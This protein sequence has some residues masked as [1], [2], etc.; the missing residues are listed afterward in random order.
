VR[1]GQA[2]VMVGV[3]ALLAGCGGGPLPGSFTSGEAPA[4]LEAPPPPTVP[5]PTID[6]EDLEDLDEEERAELLRELEMATLEEAGEPITGFERPRLELLLATYRSRLGPSVLITDLTI[7]D[8]HA[9]LTAQD[10]ELTDNL[11]EYAIRRGVLEPP[12]PVRAQGLQDFVDDL[13]PLEEVRAELLAAVIADAPT[14]LPFSADAITHLIIERNVFH[15][16]DVTIR[17]Y[18]SDDRRSGSVLY[19][20]HGALLRVFG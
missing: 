6:L 10:P 7:W 11:D 5:G 13:F 14:H 17:V 20:L 1:L 3:L 12:T 19:A 4:P 18:M 15:D 8:A 9:R 16:H 2:V